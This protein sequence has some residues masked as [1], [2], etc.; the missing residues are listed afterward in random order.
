M[1]IVIDEGHGGKDPGTVNK[2]LGFEEAQFTL[3]IGHALSR[4]CKVN[5]HEVKN[6]RQTRQDTP[7]DGHKNNDL[8]LRSDTS[9]KF[10]ADCFISIHMN[11]TPGG[12]GS[13]RGFEVWRNRAEPLFSSS[14]RLGR[15]LIYAVEKVFPKMKMRLNN[16]AN[17]VKVAGFAVLRNTKA[18]AIL[19]ECGFM[20]NREDAMFF[21]DSNN[22][23]LFAEALY[24][25]I[26]V[27]MKG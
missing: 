25:G 13:A 11:A 7:A 22:Q 21:A 16:S 3:E 14:D 18:P 9:N 4:I 12:T 5:G 19:V 10:K 8:F 24:R 20:D 2:A 1:R 26:V 27:W 17:P 15:G 23:K 6:T